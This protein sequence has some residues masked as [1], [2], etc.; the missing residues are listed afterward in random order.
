MNGR[1]FRQPTSTELALIK[2]LLEAEF[3][4]RDDISA[5]IINLRVRSIES[6]SSLEL[7]SDSGI[8]ARVVKQVPVEAQAKDQDG[9]DIHLLLHVVR[10]RLKELEIFKDDGSAIQQMPDPSTF[11]LIILPPVPGGSA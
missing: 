2:R 9:F 11:E 5:M 6:E 7:E 8:T 4:G 10:G 1:G 3:P